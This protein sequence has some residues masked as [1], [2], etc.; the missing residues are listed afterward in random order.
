M[1][2]RCA[3]AA[4]LALALSA[5]GCSCGAQPAEGPAGAIGPA[6]LPLA[7]AEVTITGRVVMAAPGGAARPLAG[8]D[9]HLVPEDAMRPFLAARLAAAT[10]ALEPLRRDEATA[11]ARLKALLAATDQTNQ[12]WKQTNDND[13]RRR[14]E[15]QF[16]RSAQ[17]AQAVHRDLLAEKK[18]AWARATEAAR[19]SEAAEREQTR[20]RQAADRYREGAFFLEG[21]PPPVRSALAGADGAF[22]LSV[23][24]G[25]YAVVAYG[26]QPQPADEAL[27]VWVLWTTLEPGV[28]LRLDLDASNLLGTDCAA[29]AVLVKGL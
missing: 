10:A 28:G 3:R 22:A 14:V 1:N 29:C 26:Q 2:R 21:L 17:A 20:L 7:P 18:A 4:A 8:A 6:P 13:L 9:V 15:V 27:Q 12:A 11:S 25:R 24:P 23:P 5:G 19:R 16:R